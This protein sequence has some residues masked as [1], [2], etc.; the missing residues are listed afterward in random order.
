MRCFFQ[1]GHGNLQFYCEARHTGLPV[2]SW[3]FIYIL[4]NYSHG[5]GMGDIFRFGTVRRLIG[6]FDLNG[7]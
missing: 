1:L 3:K 6:E 2:F 4:C 7:L 5:S